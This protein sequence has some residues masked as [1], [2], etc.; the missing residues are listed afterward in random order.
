MEVCDGGNLQEHYLAPD[1][2]PAF[3]QQQ[4]ATL[5]RKIAGA[6]GYCHDNG[7]VH[8]DLKLENI[9]LKG[10]P[11][12]LDVKICDFGLAAVKSKDSQEVILHYNLLICTI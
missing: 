11:A 1:H 9:M 5:T 4:V 10:E 12:A 8:R 6:V 7:I 3:S 2:S